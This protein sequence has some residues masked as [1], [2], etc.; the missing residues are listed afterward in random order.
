VYS[1]EKNRVVA[2]HSAIII[3]ALRK[4]YDAGSLVNELLG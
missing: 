2:V 3:E 4:L 1:A